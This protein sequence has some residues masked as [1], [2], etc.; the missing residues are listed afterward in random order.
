LGLFIFALLLSQIHTNTN[1]SP[2]TISDYIQ[3]IINTPGAEKF[4]KSSN[5]FTFLQK[6]VK[7]KTEKESKP[8]KLKKKTKKKKTKPKLD[9]RKIYLSGWLKISSRIFRDLNRYPLLSLPDNKI[10]HIKV[11]KK[12]FRINDLFTKKNKDPKGRKYFW[13]YLS[14]RKLY[15]TNTENNL[16]VIDNILIRHIKS[17]YSSKTKK[18][19]F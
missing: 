18:L 6:P 11:D 19:V 2:D 10:T 8:K 5:A 15:Y 9:P 1:P 12:N 14:G 7:A 13:F 4:V 3:S 16:N 17:I